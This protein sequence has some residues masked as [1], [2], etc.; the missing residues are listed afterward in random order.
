M[1]IETR[2]DPETG[3]WRLIA[4]DRALRPDDSKR[5]PTAAPV[6]PFCPGNEH[7]TPPERMRAPEG[8]T[9]WQVRV[10]PNKFPAVSTG[11]GDHE[12]VIESPRHDWDLKEASD[13]E[14]RTV[15]HA[16]RDRARALGA[17]RAAVVA[18]RNYGKAAGASL[19]HP[20]SQIVALDEAPPGLTDRW[21][22]ARDYHA[23][24]GRRLIDDAAEQERQAGDRIVAEEKGLLVYQPYAAGVP[25]QTLFV[26]DDGRAT[27]ATA[28]DDALAALAAVLPGVLA[29]LA[30]AAGDPAYNLF[31]HAGPADDPDAGQWFQWHA[32]LF[33]RVTT[34]GGLELATNLAVN[35]TSPE[36][37]APAMRAASTWG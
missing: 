28:T 34:L 32:D 7:L 6:C 4:P 16:L 31:F 1:R 11:A 22:R 2:V 30:S 27:L 33:P 12:V 13:D 5:D 26:P 35:P 3:G 14:V 10:V 20:H 25:H 19:S 17:D 36:L 21:R 29:A 37:T 18:F 24:T 23:A 8:A 9:D 15:L